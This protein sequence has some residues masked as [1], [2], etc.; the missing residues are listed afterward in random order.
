MK[1]LNGSQEIDGHQESHNKQ[2]WAKD[3]LKQFRWVERQM[4]MHLDD[5]GN[6]FQSPMQSFQIIVFL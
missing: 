1:Q 6:T 2:K 4:C 5:Q 3:N